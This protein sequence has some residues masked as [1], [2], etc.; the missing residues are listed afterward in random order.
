MH[1]ESGPSPID[2]LTSGEPEK[3]PGLQERMWQ[4]LLTF[5]EQYYAVTDYLDQHPNATLNEVWDQRQLAFPSARIATEF[6]TRLKDF[7]ER[8]TAIRSEIATAKELYDKDWET[9]LF[10]KWT[11]KGSGRWKDHPPQGRITVYEDPAALIFVCENGKD[12]ATAYAGIDGPSYPQFYQDTFGSHD[13]DMFA[14]ND[15]GTYISS[16]VVMVNA[17]AADHRAY[18]G[19]RAAFQEQFLSTKEAAIFAVLTHERQHVINHLFLRPYEQASERYQQARTEV[20]NRT[21]AV[22]EVSEE[23]ETDL[24]QEAISAKTLA[25]VKQAVEVAA[26]DLER[27]LFAMLPDF[28]KHAQENTIKEELLAFYLSDTKPSEVKKSLPG[29]IQ[30][31]ESRNLD[32]LFHFRSELNQKLPPAVLERIGIVARAGEYDESM[33]EAQRQARAQQ[34]NAD[35]LSQ[36]FAPVYERLRLMG[37]E[38]MQQVANGLTQLERLLPSDDALPSKELRTLMPILITHPL[39]RWPWIV[40]QAL[41]YGTG[42]NRPTIEKRNSEDS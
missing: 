33:T 14:R 39:D 10:L 13:D 15:D 18:E 3:R 28:S 6:R 37:Q 8:R 29:Y 9:Q 26:D 19:Q 22:L 25:K 20:S 40:D 4:Q 21:F 38:L 31:C 5:S 36:R 17:E 34:V 42:E 27:Q 24:K 23:L 12:F 7:F 2:P 16:S 1:R 30:G 11:N 32:V 35:W 41:R